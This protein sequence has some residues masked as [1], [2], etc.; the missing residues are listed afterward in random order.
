MG[1]HNSGR[2]PHADGAEGVARESR[3]AEAERERSDAAGGCC[4]EAARVVEG[5]LGRKRSA[6]LDPKGEQSPMNTQKA[7]QLKEREI[8]PLDARGVDCGSCGWPT[9]VLDMRKR[10]FQVWRRR[11]CV[12]PQCGERFSTREV[13]E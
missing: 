13:M 11:E 9:R 4:R 7:D 3:Q 8:T 6:P 5:E 12:N 2:R 1:N 10:K